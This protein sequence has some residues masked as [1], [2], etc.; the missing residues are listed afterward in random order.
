MH[1][2]TT[3][4]DAAASTARAPDAM[5][6]IKGN[7]A[8]RFGMVVNGDEA[9]RVDVGGEVTLRWLERAIGSVFRLPHAAEESESAVEKLSH[10]VPAQQV[11]SMH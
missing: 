5:S 10:Y 1:S 6:S 4:A 11:S 8:F 7:K 2:D 9:S 3:S